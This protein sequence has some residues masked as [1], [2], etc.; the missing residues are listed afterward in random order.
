MLKDSQEETKVFLN[1]A[2]LLEEKL[3][4]L[5]LQLPPKFGQQ[6]MPSLTDYLRCLTKDHRYAIEIRN[7]SL[8]NEQL[9]LS[10]REHNVALVW[11]DSD[12]MPLAEETTADF[13]Y[14]RWEGDRQS[15]KGTLGKIEID[16]SQSVQAWASKLKT[17]GSGG[18]EVFGYFSKYFSGLPPHDAAELLQQI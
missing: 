8:L 6:N 10:F 12:K 2:S 13:T 14:I 3:G 9:Y 17:L 15:V 4:V 1:R 5:L 11:V 18:T 7:K 16:R